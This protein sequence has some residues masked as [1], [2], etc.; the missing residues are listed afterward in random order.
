LGIRTFRRRLG[1]RDEAGGKVDPDVL[2]RV[3]D[4]PERVVLLKVKSVTPSYGVEPAW[5][6]RSPGVADLRTSA[7]KSCTPNAAD[8]DGAATASITTA[9]TIAIPCL[10]PQFPFSSAGC[11]SPGA[12]A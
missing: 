10:I 3:G 8:A 4:D 12:P 7:L 2:D 6:A 9:A 5:V 11:P 1:V